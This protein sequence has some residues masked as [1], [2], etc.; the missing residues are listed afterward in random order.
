MPQSKP[1]LPYSAAPRISFA[2]ASPA[3]AT[4]AEACRNGVLDYLLP[5]TVAFGG[6]H[7]LITRATGV[8]TSPLAYALLGLCVAAYALKRVGRNAA[9]V[10]AYTLGSFCLLVALS[11]P[12]EGR[13]NGFSVGTVYTFCFYPLLCWLCFPKRGLRLAAIALTMI[14]LALIAYQGEYPSSPARVPQPVIYLGLVRCYFLIAITLGLTHGFERTVALFDGRWRR[15]LGKQQ[16]LN[17]RLN[18]QTRDLER[19]G[20]AHRQTMNHLTRSESKYRNLFEHAFDGIAI[21]DARTGRNTESNPKLR[22]RLGYTQADFK[23]L[24]P[25]DLGAST[26]SSGQSLEDALRAVDERLA[27]EPVVSYPFTAVTREGE[28][29]EYQVTTFVLPNEDRLRINV[30]RD[31]THDL[32]TQRELTDA[33]QELRAFAHAASHDLKEPLRTMTNFSQL[34]QRR[35]AD[36]LDDGGREYLRFIDEAASRG[37]T[38]VQDLLRYAE[39]GTARVD[40]RPTDFNEAARAV[41]QTLATRVADLG[42][43]LTIETLPTLL[44]TPT[45]AQQLL[46][47]LISNALKF[48]RP[49]EV[50]RV[51]VWSSSDALGH[52]LHVSDNGIGIPTEDLDEVFGVFK[53]LVGRDQFEGNGIGL[54]L[55]RRI[56]SNLGGDIRVRSTLGEGTT[57]SM[58]FPPL[59]A[60]VVHPTSTARAAGALD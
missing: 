57:F 56:V 49:G 40:T 60:P 43:V 24:S 30:F 17:A 46:Q 16:E 47:N 42:A 48:R 58:W 21:Y 4:F 20:Q 27:S 55:C 54:A 3:S 10:F 37:I 26:Q 14:V 22:E 59:D 29:V 34:L 32:E 9:A 35:Y 39:L 15:A 25:A 51:R 6:L 23:R 53:R 5:I 52:H 41:R 13:A 19:E 44:A 1:V 50:P 7:L 31:V 18:A 33:N 38:L 28:R 45:W 8:V 2:S 12:T 11:W 36:E